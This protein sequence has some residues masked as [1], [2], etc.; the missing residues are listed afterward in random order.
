LDSNRCTATAWVTITQTPTVSISISSQM[1]ISCN[2]ES[3]GSATANAATGGTPPYTYSWT[4]GRGSSLTI[5]N[6][7]AGIYIITATD[8]NG[9]FGT[10]SVTITQPNILALSENS[11]NVSC[12]GG[13]TGSSS[14]TPSGGT[15]PYTFSWSN[16]A[17]SSS[18]SNLS[19]GVYLIKVTDYNG[20]TVTSSVTITQPPLLTANSAVI[21]NNSCKGDSGGRAEVSVG[22]GTGV[23]LYSWAPSGGNSN[24]ASGLPAGTYTV[25]VTDGNNCRATATVTITQPLLALRYSIIDTLQ[26]SGSC[27]GA[28]TISAGGGTMPYTYFW[29]PS[30]QTGAT[31]TNLCAGTIYCCTVTDNNGCTGNDS[32]Y[33]VT[34]VGIEDITNS[35]DIDIYP[36]P[37]NGYF[38]VDGLW[39]GQVMVLY[40]YLGQKIMSLTADEITVHI[41]ISNQPNGVYL[42]LITT[43]DG[44]LLREQKIVKTNK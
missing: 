1:N 11:I 15:F 35:S 36:D 18:I 8:R 28:A 10:A 40:N 21:S 43:G 34:T 26:N 29:S 42:I 24:I 33:L 9:C 41:N 17:I 27:T 2:G 7:I 4:S 5:S 44:T 23:Y 32:C 19:A 3:D 16:G 25:T 6:L 20:C 12:N 13:I 14:T 39:R 30:G 37:N 38:T 22:G 31:A